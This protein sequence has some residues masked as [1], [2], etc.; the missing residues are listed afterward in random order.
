MQLI[1]GANG[2]PHA[3][4]YLTGI[5]AESAATFK[6]S[7][8]RQ[9]ERPFTPKAFRDQRLR[10]LDQADAVV[11]IRVGMSESSAFELAYHIFE[12]R[13]TPL[14]FLVWKHAPIKTTLLR[15]LDDL[16]DVTYIEFEH[17]AELR[18]GIHA[19]FNAIHTGN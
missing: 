14:L 18:A 12:G 5:V 9:Y 10:L 15:E 19:F 16:V 6:K 3:F 13:R 17:A 7:F 4:D 8:E 11:N 2:A 1:D